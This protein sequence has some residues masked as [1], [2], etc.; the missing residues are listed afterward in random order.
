VAVQ[1]YPLSHPNGGCGFRIEQGG[2]SLAFFPDNEFTF[3]H[4]GGRAFSGYVDFCRG[5]NVLVHDAEYR[6]EEYAAFSRGWGHS[7]YKDTVRLGVEAGVDRLLMWHTNQDRTDEQAD[8]LLADARRETEA[9][10]SRM[11]CEMAAAG[12]QIEV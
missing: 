8:A 9:A 1:R 11:V 12:M 2:R 3:N 5:C 7:V 10:G 6:P 4:Q